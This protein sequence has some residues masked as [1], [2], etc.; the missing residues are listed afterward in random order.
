MASLT[1]WMWVSVNSGSWWWT[2][3]PGVLQ[4]M[5][6]QRVRYDWATELNW[7]EWS[8]SFPYFLQFKSEFGNKEFMIESQSAPSLVFADCIELLF[9][10]AK[11][12]ISLILVLTIWWC[13]CVESSLCVA[14]SLCV[15]GGGCLLWPVHSLGKTLL[16]FDLFYFVLQGQNCLLSIFLLTSYFCIPVPYNEKDTFFGCLF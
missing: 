15:V 6:S 4:F 14:S 8:S 13:P 16:A 7:T 10:A 12:I 2:G 5:V 1:R 3:R 11:N 9:L